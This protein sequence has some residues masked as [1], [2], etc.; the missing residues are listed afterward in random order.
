MASFSDVILVCNDWLWPSLSLSILLL[1]YSSASYR[2]PSAV[3]Y[4]TYRL[5]T[6]LCVTEGDDL[7]ETLAAQLYCTIKTDGNWLFWSLKMDKQVIKD[8]RA[9]MDAVSRIGDIQINKYKI[10]ISLNLFYDRYKCSFC[11]SIKGTYRANS[12]PYI[13]ILEVSHR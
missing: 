5:A 13:F 3:E 8:S 9:E 4:A 2:G 10:R 1:P 6:H 12:Q 7:R 11:C